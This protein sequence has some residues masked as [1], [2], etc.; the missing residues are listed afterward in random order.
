MTGL[1]D[2]REGQ[3]EQ[4]TSKLRASYEQVTSKLNGALRNEKI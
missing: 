3:N 2:E 4:V 1:T